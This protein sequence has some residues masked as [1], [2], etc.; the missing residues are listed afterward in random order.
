MH[1]DYL[2]T[3]CGPLLIAGG[4]DGLHFVE[5]QD[6]ERPR[7]IQ[8]D[9]EQQEKPL[10]EAKKQLA[11]YFK[12][13]LKQ[14]DLPLA[15]LGTEFQRQVW[16]ALQAIPYGETI[17]YQTLA[18]RIGKPKAVRAVGAANGRNRLP[19]VIP[20]HR[21]IGSNGSLTGFAG[22]VPIKQWLLDHE[23]ALR[24]LC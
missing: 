23:S 10:R 1:Y 7:P 20:C 4:D 9:W 24:R 8:A 19:V 15:L 5:F 21:V 2:E 3:P 18:Q 12:G 6:G 16:E 14:F 17:S 11:A 22:G 13:E